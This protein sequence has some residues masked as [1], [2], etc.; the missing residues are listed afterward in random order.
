M[1]SL[2]MLSVGNDKHL[3]SMFVIKSC[4]SHGVNQNSCFP[5]LML[6]VGDEYAELLVGF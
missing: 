4:C 5:H 2:L 6:F 1:F 3:R